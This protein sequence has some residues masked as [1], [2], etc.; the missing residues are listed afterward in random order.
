M[1]LAL[2]LISD[3]ARLS[4]KD[5]LRAMMPF[6]L[7]LLGTLAIITLAEDLTLWLPRMMR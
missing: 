5:L 3:I 2:F 4:M 1:G 6:Y 7:P